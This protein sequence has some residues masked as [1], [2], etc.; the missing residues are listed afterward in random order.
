MTTYVLNPI[1]DSATN[2]TLPNSYRLTAG[3]SVVGTQPV[4]ADE[5]DATYYALT[6]TGSARFLLPQLD[7]D[8]AQVTAVGFHVRARCDSGATDAGL[9]MVIRG[10]DTTLGAFSLYEGT[11]APSDGRPIPLTSSWATVDQVISDANY[12]DFFFDTGYMTLERM[13]AYLADDGR[14]LLEL[15]EVG[16]GGVRKPISVAE[17]W[18]W[19]E[20]GVEIPRLRQDP[21]A[22]IRRIPAEQHVSGLRK[23]G[24]YQ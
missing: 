15:S 12:G 6:G 20:A 22:R 5:D 7:V 2:T 18:L 4:L 9:N 24:G 23:V 13:A 1:E 14:A 16:L 8:P 19:V 21:V 10:Y 11:A 17:A 3:A